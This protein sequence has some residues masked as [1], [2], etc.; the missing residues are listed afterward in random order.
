MGNW[1]VRGLG[2]IKM[3]ILARILVPQDFGIL[4]LAMLAV[5]CLSVFSE[6]GLE[7]ALIQKTEVQRDDLNTAW[8]MNIVRGGLLFL[9]LFATAGL[10]ADY[11]GHTDLKMVLRVMAICFIFE[12]FTNI[13][14]I[15]FQKDIDFRKKAKLELLSDICGS[16][17]AVLLA[18]VLR[19]V[20][21]L[22]DRQCHLAYELLLA[23][24]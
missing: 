22:S 7:T 1:S 12:G 5:G 19:N 3:I 14:V 8:T 23:V 6:I 10:I 21:A 24:L 17:S 11:F 15:Y 18:L 4:G 16:V 13:G 9:V 2:T 20:W